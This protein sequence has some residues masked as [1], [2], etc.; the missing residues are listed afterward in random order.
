MSFKV[1]GSEVY[2]HRIVVAGASRALYQELM[3]GEQDSGPIARITVGD[4][5]SPL[6]PEAVEL[7]VDYMYTAK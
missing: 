1:S 3:Q 7:L 6:N 5:H 4:L 2:C